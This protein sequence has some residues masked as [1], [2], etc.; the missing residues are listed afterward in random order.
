[1]AGS[2]EDIAALG[3]YHTIELPGGIVTPG[4]YDHRPASPRLPWPDSLAGKRCLDVGS[5][6]GFWAFEMWR[7][8]AA[9]VVSI[10]LEDPARQEWQGA[11]AT[12]AAREAVVSTGHWEGQENLTRRSFEAARSALGAE[13][14]IRHDLSVYDV[15]PDLLGQFDFVFMGSLLLH[16]RDP[17]RALAAVR[18]VTTER[19]LLFEP[20]LATLSVL[21]PRTPVASLWQL[22]EP[23][24]WLPN[25][26]GLRRLVHAAGFRVLDSGGPIAQRFGAAFPRRPPRRWPTLSELV[27]WSTVRPLGVPSGW[28]LAEPATDSPAEH[29]R[30]AAQRVPL[31]GWV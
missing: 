31:L 4:F 11:W 28:T 10:D 24:W 1:V 8:G 5:S 23:R 20:I 12:G 13:T 9:E 26:A 14:I 25:L 6:D 21:L 16:L 30:R 27:F 15:S 18:S 2:P 29:A 7:R 19:F 3:W 17:S 22:D